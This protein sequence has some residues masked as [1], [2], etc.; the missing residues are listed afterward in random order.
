MNPT[1][2]PAPYIACLTQLH[3]VLF[4]L[5]PDEARESAVLRARA[6]DYIDGITGHRST[7]IEGDWSRAEEYLRQAYRSART[8]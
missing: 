3:S 4:N 7:D 8:R 1:A 6:T 2:D 5:S